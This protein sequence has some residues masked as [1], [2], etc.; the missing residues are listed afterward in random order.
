MQSF[1]QQSACHLYKS[2]LLGTKWSLGVGSI[3]RTWPHP[4]GPGTKQGAM[5]HPCNPSTGRQGQIK[6]AR[7]NSDSVRLSQSLRWRATEDISRQPLAS[8]R[9][10]QVQIC[11]KQTHYIGTHAR[12]RVCTELSSLKRWRNFISMKLTT[13]HD[14]KVNEYIVLALFTHSELFRWYQ[15]QAQDVRSQYCLGHVEGVSLT[16]PKAPLPITLMI[17]KSSRWSCM[18]FTSWVKGLAVRRNTV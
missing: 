7:L 15:C 2:K 10:P 3:C 6:P 14:N 13:E 9:S 17:S 18:S 8:N 11:S 16:S 12:T 1:L 4:Q 5:L